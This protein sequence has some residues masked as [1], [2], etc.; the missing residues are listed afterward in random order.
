MKDKNKLQAKIQALVIEVLQVL[1]GQSLLHGIMV[2][3]S[4]KKILEQ[5][6]QNQAPKDKHNA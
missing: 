4:A 3:D 6:I 1:D 2:L 5:E